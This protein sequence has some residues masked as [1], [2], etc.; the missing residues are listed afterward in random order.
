M[1]YWYCQDCGE[2]FADEDARVLWEDYGH[3]R[4]EH[5]A[6]PVCRS[7]SVTEAGT[8]KICGKPTAD[9]EYC[10]DCHNA[11]CD[12]W[13]KLVDTVYSRRAEGNWGKSEDWQ[14][15]KYAVCDWLEDKGVV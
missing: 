15:C 7:L 1:K 2:I 9:E 10:E 12:A 4:I 8:C 6:C 3:G 5:T 11:M 13:E 14:D